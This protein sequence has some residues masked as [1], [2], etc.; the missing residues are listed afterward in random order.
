LEVRGEEGQTSKELMAFKAAA[1][2]MTPWCSACC[3]MSPENSTR[4]DRHNYQT[5]ILNNLMDHLLAADVLLG[6][7]AA[8]PAGSSSASVTYTHLANNV[9]YLA[10][11]IVDK[12]WQGLSACISVFY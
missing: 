8:L 11:R 7:Q 1:L 10:G 6:D 2:L 5:E 12:L 4:S 9:F 3:Q